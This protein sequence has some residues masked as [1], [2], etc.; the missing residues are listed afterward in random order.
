MFGDYGNQKIHHFYTFLEE[1]A[2]KISYKMTVCQKS[3]K[4]GK[5]AHQTRK[6]FPANTAKQVKSSSTNI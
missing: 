4:S 6:I 3:D 5:K 2:K 1:Y